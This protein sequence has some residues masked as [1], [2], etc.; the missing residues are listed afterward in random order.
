MTEQGVVRGNIG[1][2]GSVGGEAEEEDATDT[3]DAHVRDGGA[4]ARAGGNVVRDA[5]PASSARYDGSFKSAGIK[6]LL[7]PR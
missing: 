1:P 4:D 3:A 5:G 2:G 7:E 6:Y